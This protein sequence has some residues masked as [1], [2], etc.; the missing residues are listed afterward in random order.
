LNAS[1]ILPARQL[2]IEEMG[3]LERRPWPRHN[4]IVTAGTLVGVVVLVR[5]VLAGMMDADQ[6]RHH[7]SVLFAAALRRM[8]DLETVPSGSTSGSFKIH[9]A[10][11]SSQLAPT[12]GSAT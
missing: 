5:L 9:P 10:M 7:T 12:G 6:L 11:L 2:A 4:A 8:V 1:T 3:F